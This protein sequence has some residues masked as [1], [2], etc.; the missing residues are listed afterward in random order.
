MEKSPTS[1]T[2][3]SRWIYRVSSLRDQ[4]PVK[5]LSGKLKSLR[6]SRAEPSL[7]NFLELCQSFRLHFEKFVDDAVQ[8]IAAD[9][10]D[11]SF[12]FCIS[13]R[14]SSSFMVALK[15]LRNSCTRSWESPG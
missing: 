13:A 4:T 10:I 3:F 14:K 6:G 9:Q 7:H 12:S 15:T 8:V 1:A 5:S 11:L 2:L